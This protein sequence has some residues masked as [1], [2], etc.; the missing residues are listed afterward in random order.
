MIGGDKATFHI[1]GKNRMINLPAGLV[2]EIELKEGKLE[3]LDILKVWIEKTGMKAS[4]KTWAFKKKKEIPRA[5]LLVERA[6]YF[7]ESGLTLEEIKDKLN[8]MGYAY[9]ELPEDV[10]QYIEKPVEVA[11]TSAENENP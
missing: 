6:K 10:Q 8:Q 9:S 11:E 5:T 4:P 1:I 7:K 2:R 3:H